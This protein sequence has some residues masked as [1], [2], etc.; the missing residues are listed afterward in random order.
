MKLSKFQADFFLLIIASMWGLSFPLMKYI[1]N[2]IGTFQLLGI[3]F[4]IGGL[5]V[6]M[7]FRGHLKRLDRSSI[8]AGILLGFLLFASNSAQVWGLQYTTST[9]SAFIT[10]L[11]VV[12]VPFFSY[13]FLKK[14]THKSAI[15]G[16][17]FATAGLYLLTCGEGGLDA[18]NIGDVITLISA[19][20]FGVYYVFIEKYVKT[21]KSIATSV[22]ILL[23]AAF[24]YISAWAMF[25]YQPIEFSPVLTA[26]LLITSLICTAMCYSGH[27]YVQKFTD[28]VHASLI[29]MAEPMFATI[30]S[31]FIPDATGATETIGL[32]KLCGIVL[33]IIGMASAEV[34]SYAI[35]FKNKKQK[36]DQT[37]YRI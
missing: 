13:L 17:I 10:G 20:I 34:G 23:S 26:V 11:S 31:S 32:L 25:E 12:S 19:L 30:F 16:V 35:N 36:Y 7:I 24:F 22:V 5:V 2:D 29:I 15:I 21:E 4:G 3:R 14:K 18:I 37:K 9:N 28:P 6:A 27:V 1:I 8:S 33:M